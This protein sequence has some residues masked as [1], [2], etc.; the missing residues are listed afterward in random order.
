MPVPESTAEVTV[1]PVAEI[2]R[3]IGKC[4]GCSIPW[5]KYRGKRRCPT[6]GVPLL[7]CTNCLK[8]DADKH[9]AKC[10]LCQED[11]KEK[12]KPFNKKLH[13]AE[14]MGGDE[15]GGLNNK[16]SG[17]PGKRPKPAAATHTCGVC[18]EAFKSRN[19][20]FKH[21]KESGHATRK[22]KKMKKEK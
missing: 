9:G 7:L 19:A 22:A 5:S 15:E 10:H 18:E 8:T 20:L 1:A 14:I 2:P 11:E 21:I 17:A 13:Y 3:V 12:R 4:A 16:N 6:C